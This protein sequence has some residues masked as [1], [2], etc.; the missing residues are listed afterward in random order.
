M[1]YVLGGARPQGREG[2][3]RIRAL[4]HRSQA[5]SRCLPNLNGEPQVWMN[6]RDQVE[7]GPGRVSTS[8]PHRHLRGR[9]H[10][11]S[12]RVRSWRCSSIPKW[13]HTDAGQRDPVELRVRHLRLRTR[14]GIRRI[15]SA[16]SRQEIRAIA[17]DR[18]VFFFVSGGVDS[19]VAYTL[20]L[21]ALGPERVFGIYVDTGLD[22]RRRDRL[23]AAPVPATRRH[24]VSRGRS[25]SANS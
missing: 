13:S 6:H 16:R 19:T 8:W 1:A 9:R 5:A 22:A 14:T 17:A 23:R 21:R 24:G 10:G 11:A 4:S 15:A 2:R 12:G 3:V 25:R 7:R 20:C 18:N